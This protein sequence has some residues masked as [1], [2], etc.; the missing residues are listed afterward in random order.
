MPHDSPAGAPICGRNTTGT[1]AEQ[2]RALLQAPG[3]TIGVRSRSAAERK[4]GL[5]LAAPLPTSA[6]A[7]CSGQAV[8]APGAR[9]RFAR[10]AVDAVF[11]SVADSGGG[12]ARCALRRTCWPRRRRGLTEPEAGLRPPRPCRAPSP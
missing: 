5:A 7:A 2:R 12:A 4:G 3:C 6:H 11:A 1:Q 9:R 8:V 10:R